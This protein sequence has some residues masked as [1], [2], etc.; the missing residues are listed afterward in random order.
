MPGSSSTKAPYLF[1]P[2]TTPLIRV[3]SAYR[4]DAS[5]QG[6][7]VCCFRSQRDPLRLGVDVQHRGRD[8]LAHGQV[9]RRPL[10][11]AVPRDVLDV[12]HPVEA[13]LDADKGPVIRQRDDRTLH[14]LADRKAVVR[15][16]PGVGRQAPARQRD[17]AGVRLDLHHHHLNLVINLQVVL[18][19]GGA[20]PRNLRAG[21]QAVDSAEVDE[22]AEIHEPFDTRLERLPDLQLREHGVALRRAL[23][24]EQLAPGDD[25]PPLARRVF[26]HDAFDVAPDPA[27]EILH[28]P[29]VD[30]RGRKERRRPDVDDQAALDRAHDPAGQHLPAGESLFDLADRGM[31][32]RLG[33]G[34]DDETRLGVLPLDDDIDFIADLVRK[35]APRRLKFMLRDDAL[36]LAAHVDKNA[37]ALN[38][39]DR[40]FQM[41]AGL[42]GLRHRAQILIHESIHLLMLAGLIFLSGLQILVVVFKKGGFVRGGH[43]VLFRSGAHA[44]DTRVHVSRFAMGRMRQTPL[45]E[46]RPRQR[47]RRIQALARST[48][49]QAP[50]LSRPGAPRPWPQ[51]VQ[52][53]AWLYVSG[54]P[55][56]SSTIPRLGL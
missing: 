18:G 43:F 31:A 32:P 4:A 28:A 24:L 20:L 35:L 54:L 21:D 9:V 15:R 5:I 50:R 40:N 39:Q 42:G 16:L 10:P 13:F 17:L 46:F 44:Q 25:D 29:Q 27:L 34:K 12:N 1:S 14:L 6:S 11:V 56:I 23:I 53:L 36:G 48:G 30:L 33:M 55:P 49:T 51:A 2:V 45:R 19:L 8:L 7:S 47:T 41:L 38:R 3:P 22:G 26:Q 52:L 37:V